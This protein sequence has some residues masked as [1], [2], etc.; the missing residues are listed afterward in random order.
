MELEIMAEGT[1]LVAKQF[2][3]DAMS[4]LHVGKHK[5]EPVL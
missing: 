3:T 2:A 4:S 1:F 5:K